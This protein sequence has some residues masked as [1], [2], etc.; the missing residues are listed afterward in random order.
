LNLLEQQALRELVVTELT[1][2][3]G[4]QRG[5]EMK[6]LCCF[7]DDHE[8]SLDVHIG[9]RITPGGFHCFSCGAHGGWNT[10]AEKLNLKRFQFSRSENT[11]YQYLNNTDPFK[12]MRSL[13]TNPEVIENGTIPTLVG[14]E[15]LPRNFE[16]RGLPRKFYE[17]LGGRY[18]YDSKHDINY[19]Y[20]PIVANQEQRGYT[21]CKLDNDRPEAVKYLTFADTKK[22]FLLYDQLETG[23][24]IVLCEGHFDAM[25]LY[26]YGLP[27]LAIFGVAN[28][29]PIKKAMLMAKSP[30][31]IVIAFDGDK[32]GYD[33][34]QEIFRDLRDCFDVDIYY[35]PYHEEKEK[36]LDPG[37]M[38]EIMIDE[39]A[40]KVYA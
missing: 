13:L 39:L 16:W 21:L 11:S 22:N 3:G 4:R 37:N 29:G 17:S 15:N 8:P 33:A 23:S 14:L 20:L 24:P 6:I 12:L 30:R 9:H 18:F 19:L 36:R 10:L 35:L 25:R 1:K 38:P 2:I 40:A 27:A 7:H 32:A 26:A 31:R 34:S 28:F 5:S